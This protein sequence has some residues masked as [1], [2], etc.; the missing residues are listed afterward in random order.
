MK[1]RETHQEEL[2]SLDKETFEW[3]YKTYYRPLCL[4][5]QKIVACEEDAEDIVQNFFVNL[6]VERESKK[7]AS[8]EAYLFRGVHNECLK[9]LEHIKVTRQYNELTLNMADN[10]DW[11][12]THDKDNPLSEL[13]SQETMSKI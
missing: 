9:Y 6:W 12:L 10:S 7:I 3:M 2:K 1:I 13:I 5:A 11:L 4:H 8:L